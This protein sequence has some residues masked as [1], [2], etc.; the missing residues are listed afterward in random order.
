MA[1]GQLTHPLPMC[2]CRCRWG[3]LGWLEAGAITHPNPYPIHPTIQPS[4][5]VLLLAWAAS[6]HPPY[7]YHTTH[8]KTLG[9]WARAG[10]CC[11][12]P[13]LMAI[14]ETD[15][16]IIWLPAGLSNPPLG[17][18]VHGPEKSAYTHTHPPTLNPH[19]PRQP[20]TYHTHPPTLMLH[21]IPIHR[22]RQGLSNP[23]SRRRQPQPW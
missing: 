1:P 21:R 16:A 3:G 14:G 17:P 4:E 19:A 11:N 7:T 23:P 15:I 9:I 18:S 20:T 10:Q 5:R 22:H 13:A 2:A 8:R 6:E 12:G